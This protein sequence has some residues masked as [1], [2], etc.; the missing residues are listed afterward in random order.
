MHLPT[1]S[2]KPDSAAG[3]PLAPPPTVRSNAFVFAAAAGAIA[4]GYALQ[5]SYGTHHP[6]A[7]AWLSVTLLCCVA[8]ILFANAS[9]PRGRTA[10]MML[11]GL[12][13]VLQLAQLFAKP[14]G[15]Y[16]SPR[17]EAHLTP[18]LIGVTL[19]AVLVAAGLST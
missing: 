4:L 13:L 8:A 9:L 10:V 16:L 7:L 14:P 15:V 2:T 17:S 1:Q 11:I 6:V 19:L 18:F 5:I 12:G 3:E